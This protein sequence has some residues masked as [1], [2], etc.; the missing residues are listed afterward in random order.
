MEK[1]ILAESPGL[2]GLLRPRTKAGPKSTEFRVS[3]DSI[4]GNG[5]ARLVSFKT[6]I[7]KNDPALPSSLCAMGLGH[8]AH[9]NSG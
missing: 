2:L 3:I 5:L 4:K 9:S 8:Y 6:F 7:L 1:K